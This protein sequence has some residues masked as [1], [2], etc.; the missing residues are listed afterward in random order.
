MRTSF[1]PVTRKKDGAEI[2]GNLPFSEHWKLNGKPVDYFEFQP[3]YAQTPGK[4]AP[5]GGNPPLFHNKPGHAEHPAP[6]NDEK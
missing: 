1:E 2:H 4:I 5:K 6:P 3:L